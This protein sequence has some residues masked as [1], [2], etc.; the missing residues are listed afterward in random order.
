[1][2]REHELSQEELVTAL[3]ESA[4]RPMTPELAFQQRVSGIMAGFPMDSTITRE[5]V[6]AYVREKGGV[7]V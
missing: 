4:K 7:T 2:A 1:M 3:R 5:Q 6:E